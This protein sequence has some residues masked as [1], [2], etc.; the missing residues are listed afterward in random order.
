MSHFGIDPR[1]AKEFWNE[2]TKEPFDFDWKEINADMAAAVVH[3][4]RVCEAFLF[5]RFPS[6]EEAKEHID[7]WAEWQEIRRN[8]PVSFFKPRKMPNVGTIGYP[9]EPCLNELTRLIRGSIAKDELCMVVGKPTNASTVR[10]EVLEFYKS[11][12]SSNPI[13]HV[14]LEDT[15]PYLIDRYL[16]TS[17]K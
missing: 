1:A 12:R 4:L 10:P 16:G 5:G 9:E 8:N 7:V 3:N 2:K 6:A 17:I 11:R 13:L 14:A 15:K